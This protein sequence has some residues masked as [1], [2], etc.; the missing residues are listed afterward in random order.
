MVAIRNAPGIVSLPSPD[1]S[2]I[3]LW[4]VDLDT[5]P[6]LSGA[7]TLSVKEE[8]R[9]RRFRF[10]VHARRYRASHVALRAILG[11][12]TGV[13]PAGLHFTE[14]PHGKPRLAHP[15]APH[16]NMS[17]SAG[18][19]LIGVCA[20]HPIGVDIELIVPMDDADVLARR[21]FTATEYAAFAGTPPAQRLEAFFR[22]WTRKEACLKALGSGL[23]IEPAEF[24]AGLGR[25][26]QGTTIA[27]HG[28][29]CPM[30]VACLDL[31]I[32][33]LAA[34]AKLDDAHSPLA[35]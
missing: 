17:H 7:A 30:R 10:E 32:E 19:A 5:G 11:H 15:G 13:D 12:V 1:R 35:F 25:Q 23:S 26:P 33:G 31:P 18:W 20:S 8:D 14:G 28:Q 21:N 34:F 9:A 24:E 2:G 27:V 6:G 3:D 4:L 22:C 29:P 16:F